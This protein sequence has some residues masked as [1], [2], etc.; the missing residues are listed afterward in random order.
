MKISKRIIA[1]LLS[2]AIAI[3]GGISAAAE[4]TAPAAAGN[5]TSVIDAPQ[6]SETEIIMDEFQ[7][8]LSDGI[9]ITD[10]DYTPIDISGCTVW[11]GK[12]K[13]QAGANYCVTGAAR[14]TSTVTIP[15]DTTVVIAE[16]GSLTIYTGGTLNVKGRLLV[17]KNGE[18]FNS[19]ALYIN[20]DSA[21]E[22][23]GTVKATV[24]S[25]TYI[26]SEY[27][28]RHDSSAVYSGTV[29][30][31]NGGVYLNYGASTLTQNAKCLV[32]GDFQTPSG[33]RLTNKGFFGVTISGRASFAGMYYLYGKSVNSGVFIFEKDVHYFKSKKASFAVSKSSRLIDYRYYKPSSSGNVDS[34]EKGID[35]SYAQGAVD[36]DMVRF[37]G[38]NFV[39]IRAS[40]GRISDSKPTAKDT[41]FDYNVTEASKAGLDVGVYHYL[42]AETVE[43]AIEEAKFFIKTIEPYKITFPVVLDVEEQ[44]Q[45]DLGK[46]EITKICK[47]FL[48]EVKAA[49]YYPMIYANKSWL[50]YNLDMSQLSDYEVWLAQWYT[51]PTYT[52]DFGIW[53]YSCKGIVTGIDT[54]VDLNLA[55]KDYAKIIREGGYNHLS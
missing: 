6:K 34:G 47:A 15:A 39:M 18:L 35:V 37:S 7:Q 32:T 54:Y 19:G 53:Q 50:T 44:S 29:N 33:G 13:P 28:I 42:Y 10:T 24:S 55:Y 11:D 8:G 1:L 27:I 45:A 51:V 36:W 43:D 30:V 4:N 14:I 41:W 46:D 3:S 38:I 12:E 17:E 22:S 2:A 25:C 9:D 5:E 52:G 48:D 26:K 21:F 20:T 16:G 31:Y 40:H 49:G 23:Y